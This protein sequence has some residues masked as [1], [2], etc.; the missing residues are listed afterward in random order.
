MLKGTGFVMLPPTNYIEWYCAPICWLFW[1][2]HQGGFA[3]AGP[4]SGGVNI[5]GLVNE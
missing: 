4:L 2:V 3:T 5:M 1:N